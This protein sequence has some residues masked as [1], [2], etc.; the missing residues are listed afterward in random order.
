MALTTLN[1]LDKVNHGWD[2]FLVVTQLS[3]H[4]SHSS[5]THSKECSK[6]QIQRIA[7]QK[8]WV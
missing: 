3:F 4:S 7:V 5:D 1:A 8:N 6:I 2:C